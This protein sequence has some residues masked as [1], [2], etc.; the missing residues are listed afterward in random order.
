MGERTWGKGSV[1][2]VIELENG[3]SALKLTTAAYRRPNGKNIHRF[4]DAKEGDEWGVS[5][6]A[7]Y[8]LRLSESETSALA[9]DRRDRDILQPHRAPP[10][11]E[12]A[13]P[14]AAGKPGPAKASTPFV[15]R[16]LQMA[17]KYL[18]GELARAK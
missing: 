17:L 2:N 16:Q 9:A 12:P 7:G 18:N 10:P 1:Q 8:E 3:R 4:P 6:D 14:D 15:D 11:K 13:R 5:P